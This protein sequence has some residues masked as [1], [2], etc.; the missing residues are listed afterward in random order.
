[1]N[2]GATKNQNK[3]ELLSLV[4]YRAKS[5]KLG[6]EGSESHIDEQFLVEAYVPMSPSGYD[7]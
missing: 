1:M 4:D 3:N 7:S 2:C 5:D 6:G